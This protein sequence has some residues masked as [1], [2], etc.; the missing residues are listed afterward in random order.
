MLD[1][2]LVL[3]GLAVSAVAAA[4]LLF[5]VGGPP[6]V[7]VGG[8]GAIL[9]LDALLLRWVDRKGRAAA[10]AARAP[11][12]ARRQYELRGPSPLRAEVPVTGCGAAEISFWLAG[13]HAGN[14]AV[15]VLDADGRALEP[16]PR[17][18]AAKADAA[19]PRPAVIAVWLDDAGP[20]ATVHVPAGG[21]WSLTLVAEV[22][23][24][25]GRM[26]RDLMKLEARSRGTLHAPLAPARRRVDRAA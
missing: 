22:T 17:P 10:D 26:V 5:A 11:V 23:A 7:T 25:D 14:Y 8:A 21:E 3:G 1:G 15:C 24:T 12:V 4:A 9:G 6:V 18:L 16:S 20:G 2:R 13:R 19:P